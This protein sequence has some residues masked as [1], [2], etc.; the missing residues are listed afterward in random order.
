MNKYKESVMLLYEALM[1][2]IDICE[3]INKIA[4][5]FKNK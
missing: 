5:L 3:K 2:A 1:G 4:K